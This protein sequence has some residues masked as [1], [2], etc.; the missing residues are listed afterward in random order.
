MFFRLFFVNALF[1]YIL[2]FSQIVFAANPTL[3]KIAVTDL[4]YEEKVKE[5]FHV[6]SAHEKSSYKEHFKDRERETPHSYS[7]SS[8]GS[9]KA[10]SE[11]N[12]YEA[13]GTY[14]YV[15]RGELHKFV[16]DIKGEMLK[17]GFYRVFQG[18]PVS[19]KDMET[20]FDIIKRIKKGDYQGAD[21]VLFGTVSNIEFRDE[22][23]PIQGSETESYILSL[24]LVADFNLINTKTFEI[25]A[26]FSAMGEGQ[27]TKLLS[28]SR[29]GHVVPNR[30]HVISDVSK[31]LGLDVAR[32]LEEQFSPAGS[33]GI[34]TTHS[35]TIEK[36]SEQ[37]I[38]YK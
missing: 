4:S 38:I 8:N 19:Q 23:T 6:V 9:I 3:P 2:G 7:A 12:Y 27:D 13:S 16:S 30:G 17:S 5:Y 31:S 18:K 11:S 20:L 28:T 10:N 32:Q 21:Y 36:K 35:S 25:M 29:G 26:A 14:S 1:F 22:V 34:N 37:V 33:H 15:E 24:E